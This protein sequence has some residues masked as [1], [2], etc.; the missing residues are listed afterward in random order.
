M[1]Q[2]G[3]APDHSHIVRLNFER[4]GTILG[5][6]VIAG[7]LVACFVGMWPTDWAKVVAERVVQLKDTIW[8]LLNNLAI[9]LGLSWGRG[10]MDK[11]IDSGGA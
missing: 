2:P 5:L 8:D 11:R 7:A 9:L 3:A 4:L 1:S 6:V 10:H